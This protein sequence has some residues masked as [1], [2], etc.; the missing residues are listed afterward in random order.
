MNLREQIE[1]EI[2][3]KVMVKLAS[4][5][6]ELGTID[7][8]KKLTE[9]SKKL[10]KEIESFEKKIKSEQKV[11]FKTVSNY[12]SMATELDKIEKQKSP[13]SKRMGALIDEVRKTSKDLGLNPNTIDGIQEVYKVK[14]QM[15]RRSAVGGQADL[16]FE[17]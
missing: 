15:T 5:R 2:T 10:I 7:D 3:E 14:E 17:M 12:N 4:E 1:K 6:V 11:L 13:L 9:E 16:I 8:L